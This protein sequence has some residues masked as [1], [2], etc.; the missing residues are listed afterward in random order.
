MLNGSLEKIQVLTSLLHNVASQ[1]AFD[2]NG[3]ATLE[4][5]REI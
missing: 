4:K 1:K 3:I 2:Q 5:T